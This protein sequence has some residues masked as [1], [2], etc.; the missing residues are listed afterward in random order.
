MLKRNGIYRPSIGNGKSRGF[1]IVELLIVIVIIAI[2]AAITIVAYNGIQQRARNANRESD[3]DAIQKGLALYKAEYNSYPT[4][5]PNPGSSSWEI[6]TDPGFMDS[7]KP[8]MSQI[9][10]G[11]SNTQYW[12]HTF[13][14]GTSG[15][16]PALGPYYILWVKGMEGKTGGADMHTGG[17]TGQTLIHDGNL[18][19]SSYAF[20]YGF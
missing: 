14:A 6:S 1:T 17:C 7:L 11:P 20:Y 9:P 18:A 19:N 8:P 15:C 4:S 10:L 2:L 3:V 12:Y 16:S 13:A 5:H